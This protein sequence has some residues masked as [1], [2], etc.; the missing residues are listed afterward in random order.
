MYKKKQKHKQVVRLLR[1][2]CKNIL[3]NFF[4]RKLESEIRNIHQVSI[5]DITDVE[6]KYKK[7]AQF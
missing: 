3:H 2:F 1:R 5:K 6:S 7:M 4:L